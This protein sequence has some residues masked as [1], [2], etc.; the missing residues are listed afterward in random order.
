MKRSKMERQL[1]WYKTSQSNPE[2]HFWN[3]LVI[4]EARELG[5]IRQKLYDNLGYIIE[6]KII[7]RGKIKDSDLIYELFCLETTG[8]Q[9]DFSKIYQGRVKRERRLHTRKNNNGWNNLI[10]QIYNGEFS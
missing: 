10:E 4:N 9:L 6:D 3:F 8:S 5:Q 2:R 7:D 1:F